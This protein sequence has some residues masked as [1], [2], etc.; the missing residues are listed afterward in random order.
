MFKTCTCGKEMNVRLRTVIYTNKVSITNVP[1]LCCED[2]TSSEVV[3]EIKNDLKYLIKQLGNQ[4]ELQE[5][6]FGESNEFAYM[7]G[8]A[9]R[10]ELSHRAIDDL[11]QDRINQ[12][13]DLLILA[14]SLDDQTWTKDIE[15]RLVQISELTFST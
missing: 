6:D 4:P 10:K 13:L 1:V 5:L 9:T 14:S 2:C 7:L 3:P 8:M 11:V 12:L 15:R